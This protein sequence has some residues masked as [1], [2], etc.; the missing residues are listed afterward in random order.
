MYSHKGPSQRMT[1][2]YS[3]SLPVDPQFT[4]NTRQNYERF[5]AERQQHFYS[6]T[7]SYSV[8]D[9]PRFTQNPRNEHTRNGSEPPAENPEEDV[10]ILADVNDLL[11]APGRTNIPVLCPDREGITTWFRHDSTVK[12]TKQILKMLKSDLPK[13]YPTYRSLP[14]E[15]KNRWFRAFAQEFNWDPSITEYVRTNYDEQAKTS[16]KAN[17]RDWKIKWIEKGADNLPD[18]M[19]AKNNLFDGYIKMWTDEKTKEM[20]AQNSINRGSKRGGLGVAKHNNGAKTYERR[21][22]E[23]TIELRTKPNMLYFM[24]QTHLDKKTRTISDMKTKQFLDK[25][26]SQVE[27]IQS[28]R[29]SDD[30]PSAQLDPLTTEEINSVMRKVVPKVRGKFYG[31]GNLFDDGCPSSSS[32]PRQIPKLQEEIQTLKAREQE[33]DAHIKFLMECNKLLLGRFPD[34][35]PPEYPETPATVED[36]D[37]TQP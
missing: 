35:R 30:D 7:P 2:S 20:A 21:W 31:F 16:F 13:A 36:E 28:Q 24:E 1:G 6:S 4:E 11:C 34:L 32:D 5:M 29:Q 37:E 23:M 19:K 25:A 27:L 22:D 3:W 12:I 15:I 33:K 14:P 26:S 9:L 17:V 18:W 8:P 10:A